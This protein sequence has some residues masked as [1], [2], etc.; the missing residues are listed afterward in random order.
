M[1]PQVRSA[2]SL[3]KLSELSSSSKQHQTPLPGVVRGCPHQGGDHWGAH[4]A[5]LLHLS[6]PCSAG[7]AM[8][9]TSPVTAAATWRSCQLPHVVRSTC[10]QV[11][12]A[13]RQHTPRGPCARALQL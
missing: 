7:T 5:L 2:H 1:P 9:L 4:T 12:T 10:V 3:P 13:H 8:N 11:F 6:C